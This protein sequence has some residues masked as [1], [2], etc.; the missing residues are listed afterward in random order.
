MFDKIIANRLRFHYITDV[1]D[2]HTQNFIHHEMAAKKTKYL[3]KII[4]FNINIIIDKHLNYLLTVV[5]ILLAHFLLR[6]SISK[7]G[8]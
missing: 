2:S 8:N 7:P 6:F 4:M 3:Q 5:I 1:F